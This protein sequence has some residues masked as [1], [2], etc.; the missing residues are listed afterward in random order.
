[1]NHNARSLVEKLRSAGFSAY[2]VTVK[3]A[4]AT[5]YKVRVGPELERQSAVNV[6][7]EIRAKMD[8]DGIVMVGD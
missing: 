2:S 4:A 8:L 5:R 3:N 6:A 7:A 1:M